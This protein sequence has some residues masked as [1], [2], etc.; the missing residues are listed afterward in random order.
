MSSN[1]QNQRASGPKLVWNIE[2]REYG[3]W[4]TI[5]TADSELEALRIASTLTLT[6]RE[7]WIR[8]ID[9]NN[10]VL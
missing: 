4:E 7:E 6:T 3:V 5:E 8:V 1:L 9:P 10:K 2:T